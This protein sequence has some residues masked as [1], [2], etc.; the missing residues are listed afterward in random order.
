MEAGFYEIAAVGQPVGSGVTGSRYC[1]L[2]GVV[3]TNTDKAAYQVPNEYICGA[4]AL[5]IGL[6][7]PPGT[8]ARLQ[9]GS[10]AFVCLRFGPKGD[11]PPPVDPV[12]V[13]QSRPKLSAGVV[14]FD[15]W[16][17]N[18]DRH[19]GNLAHEPDAGLSMFDHGHALLGTEA[20]KA[21]DSL[22]ARKDQPQWN[23]CL[24][25]HLTSAADLLAWA[26]RLRVLTNEQVEDVVYSTKR[27]GL[28]SSE[29]AKAVTETLHFRRQRMDSFLHDRH[30]Q[31]S[32]VADWG[33]AAS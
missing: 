17:L 1:T 13:A 6:P 2:H 20:G 24:L 8:V 33:L 14:I 18:G 11:K 3:K 26:H 22:A 10:L 9:D 15:C 25:P 19:A 23:G 30:D 32:G 21:V 12:K 31:F 27:L 29:E 4:L 5:A 28:I 7:S 16:V